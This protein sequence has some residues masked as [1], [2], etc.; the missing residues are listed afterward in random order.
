MLYVSSSGWVSAGAPHAPAL[1]NCLF[2]A[3]FCDPF[4]EGLSPDG[5]EDMHRVSPEH[6]RVLSIT[7]QFLGQPQGYCWA[8]AQLSLTF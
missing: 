6:F 1:I 4:L 5:T 7:G 3:I 8:V 2:G